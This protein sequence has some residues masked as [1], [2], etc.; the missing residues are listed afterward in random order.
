MSTV[1]ANMKSGLLLGG[2][3][4]VIVVI[5]ILF[6][7]RENPN[8]RTQSRLRTLEKAIT[9][10]SVEQGPKNPSRACCNIATDNWFSLYRLC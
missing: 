1:S 4:L 6:G 7:D 8:K 5:L 9:S 2:V 10:F 3:G